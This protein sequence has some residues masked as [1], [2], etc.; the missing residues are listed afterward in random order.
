MAWNIKTPAD[1]QAAEKAIQEKLDCMID[2]VRSTTV[3]AMAD[4][5][6]DC[7]GRAVERA[8]VE[9]GDLRGSGFAEVNQSTIAMGNQN[10]DI[11]MLGAPGEASGDEI[12]A[13]IGFTAPYAFVQH[14]HTEFNHPLGGQAKYLESVVAENV[15]KWTKHLQDAGVKGLRGDDS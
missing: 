10:G 1:Y 4:V 13:G 7:L 12:E 2:D 3:Q 9:T 5:A 15:P 6:L 8:P 14:E 11:D